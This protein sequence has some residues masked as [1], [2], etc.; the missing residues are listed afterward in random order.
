AGPN[1]TF[2]V[3]TGGGNCAG[4]GEADLCFMSGDTGD[5]GDANYSNAATW[6]SGYAAGTTTSITLG[7][8]TKG[9]INNLQVGSMI[10]LDQADDTSD[11][12]Q[13]YVCQA[14]GTCSLEG[15]SLN[16]RA[17]R[18]QQQPVIVK[19]ISG[20][21]PWTVGISP[22]IRMPNISSGKSPQA[23]WDNGLPVQGDG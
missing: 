2:L 6:T 5:G 13:V 16:G 15:G 4:W 7:S 9:S 10:F 12:G 22:A 17:G 8:I 20:S 18:G 23:W 3:F 21:G 11:T 19:S 14:S 1:Q